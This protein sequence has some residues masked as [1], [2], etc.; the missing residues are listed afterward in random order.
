MTF[1]DSEFEMVVN[2][3]GGAGSGRGASPHHTAR[4]VE[5]GSLPA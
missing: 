1:D 3:R 2:K 5:L 4:C